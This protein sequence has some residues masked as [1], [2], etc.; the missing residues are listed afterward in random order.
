MPEAL[1]NLPSKKPTFS[2]SQ[3]QRLQTEL[4]NCRFSYEL[5]LTVTGFSDLSKV[6]LSFAQNG[7]RLIDL[8]A[9]DSGKVFCKVSDGEHHQ[10]G[11]VD[12]QRLVQDLQKTA[13]IESWTTQA[14]YS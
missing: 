13:V 9:A 10:S 6:C 7:L 2:V 3:I 1:A 8:R 14:S 11:L 4:P 5:I 12:L